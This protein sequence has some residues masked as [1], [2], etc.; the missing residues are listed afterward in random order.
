VGLLD[1]C[2][3]RGNRRLIDLLVVGEPDAGNL[4]AEISRLEKNSTGK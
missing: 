1:N 3:D 2:C 4:A